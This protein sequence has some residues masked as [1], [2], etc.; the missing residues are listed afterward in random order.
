MAAW[1]RGGCDSDFA[2]AVAPGGEI[3][4]DSAAV[5][6]GG[7][8][9]GHGAVSI[10]AVRM[11]YRAAGGNRGGPLGQTRARERIRLR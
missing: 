2:G 3:S 7:C 8:G 6:G 10:R 4:G 1:A 11:S 5:C 9:G